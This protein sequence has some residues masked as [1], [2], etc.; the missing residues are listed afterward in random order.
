MQEHY[1]GYAEA[2]MRVGELVAAHP[3]KI[4][5]P[6]ALYELRRSL[7]QRAGAFADAQSLL[8]RVPYC[9]PPQFPNPWGLLGTTVWELIRHQ[10]E[11]PLIA[12]RDLDDSCDTDG[13]A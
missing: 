10:V 1:I 12:I 9:P 11:A 6:A 7:M 3:R 4:M 2:S 5:E 13:G 8:R